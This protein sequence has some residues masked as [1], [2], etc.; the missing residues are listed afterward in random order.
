MKTA[1]LSILLSL[2]FLSAGAFAGVDAI[3][4]AK[5][6]NVTVIFKNSFT[7]A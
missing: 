3:P 7:P 6:Q 1:I 5:H 4:T 2:A